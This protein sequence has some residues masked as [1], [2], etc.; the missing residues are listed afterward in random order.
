MR[1]LI[2]IICTLFVL[3][4]SAIRADN[5]D[6]RSNYLDVYL[7]STMSD[8][9]NYIL[10][11]QL[12]N[13]GNYELNDL[14]RNALEMKYY[15]LNVTLPKTKNTVVIGSICKAEETLHDDAIEV[16]KNCSGELCVEVDNLRKVC[17]IAR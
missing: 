17:A 4:S 7:L 1:S 15:D 9:R 12:S 13:S 14:I 5:N 10:A 16:S 11:L 6:S 2:C 8:V 3:H